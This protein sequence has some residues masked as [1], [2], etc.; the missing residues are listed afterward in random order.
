MAAKIQKTQT[1]LVEKDSFFFWFNYR[2]L[3]FVLLILQS[4]GD[5]LA[6]PLMIAH[7]G[8]GQNYPENT[9]LAFSKAI[10]IGCFGI[11]LDVQVTKDD[12]VV[13]YHPA[14]L[15]VWTNG[16]GSISSKNWDE[17]ALLDAGYHFDPENCYP[18]RSKGLT[19]P[20]LTDV[21][22]L[23]PEICIIVD[24][25]SFEY[26]KLLLA[27]VDSISD[28]EA[29][30]LV[31]YATNKEPIEWL[32]RYKPDWQTFETRDQTR[33]R[34]L[35]YNQDSQLLLP[36]AASWIGFELKRVMTVRETFALGE[37]ISRVEFHLWRPEMI[38]TL[39]KSSHPPKIVLFGINTKNE[40]DEAVYLDVDMI[41]TDNPKKIA[42][43][44]D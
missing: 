16:S 23:F 44:L 15:S 42:Q 41:Y 7:R 24:L 11:E 19:I 20:R 32:N 12:V 8:G 34:L 18:Y 26:E 43:F 10:E 22:R 28:E 33:L 39:R 27:L 6:T 29:K 3:F 14:D 40:W 31:F 5:L 37:G 38:S 17:I 25:K 1:K 21:L 13:V 35:E 2:V 4:A 36:V 9:L 30:R